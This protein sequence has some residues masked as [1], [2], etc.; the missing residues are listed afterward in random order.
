MPS[1]LFVLLG[2]LPKHKSWWV[3]TS[4]LQLWC[5]LLW[6]FSV[7]TITWCGK[8]FSG[9][10][11]LNFVL[12]ALSLYLGDFQLW[13]CWMY[14]LPLISSMPMNHR[15]DLCVNVYAHVYGHAC[16]YVH[17]YVEVSEVTLDLTLT[18]PGTHWASLVGSRPRDPS[19]NTSSALEFQMS[20][21]VPGVL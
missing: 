19:V 15:F 17:V 10:D 2:N 4:S 8:T 20:A 6:L 21:A 7:L 3:S 9:L 13:L 12:M 11:I 14:F 1:W 18:Q 5:P 16:A